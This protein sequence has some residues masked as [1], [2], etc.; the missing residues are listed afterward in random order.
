[1]KRK[2]FVPFDI[3]YADVTAKMNEMVRL[4][5]TPDSNWL[6]ALIKAFQSERKKWDQ[7]SDLKEYVK[8]IS[9]LHSKSLRLIGGA[10]L[11][12]AYDLPRAMAD[13]WPQTGAWSNGPTVLRASQIYLEINNVFPEVMNKNS[14]KY[15]VT[16]GLSF[17]LRVKKENFFVETAQTWIDMLRR[18]AWQHAQMLTMVPNRSQIEKR[19]LQALTASADDIRLLRVLRL[20]PLD[21]AMLSIN[22]IFPY[23]VILVMKKIIRQYLHSMIFN[24]EKN[25][26]IV[27]VWG[28]ILVEY[29][30]CLINNP[31]QFEEFRFNMRNKLLSKKKFDH[32]AH[33]DK[34]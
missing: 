10:Y 13:E 16:G 19:M 24:K 8:A 3:V 32:F 14:I 22:D 7:S 4:L 31:E 5:G 6:S 18:G 11:H 27:S 33:G 26:Y 2:I 29:L 17:I 30:N 15:R 28:Y 34:V 23:F 12:I 9:R 21:D 25:T 1:M 20:R